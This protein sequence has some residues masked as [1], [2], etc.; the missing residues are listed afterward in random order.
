MDFVKNNFRDIILILL[1][2]LL[3]YLLVRTFSPTPDNSELLNYKLE[4]LDNKILETEK[5]QKQLDDSLALYKKDIL[6]IDKNIDNIKVQRTVIYNYYQEK[7]K[8]ISGFT[9]KQIDSSLR[10][11]YNF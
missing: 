9:N 1:G 2:C 4:Q 11:R 10:Q 5:R 6:R 7:Q 3:V 8:E